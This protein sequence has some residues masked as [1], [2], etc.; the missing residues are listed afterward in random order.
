MVGYIADVV[1]FEEEVLRQLVLN[2]ERVL[3]DVGALQCGVDA[4]DCGLK[5]GIVSR[6][7]ADGGEIAVVVLRVGE[8]WRQVQ[9]RE[10]GVALRTEVE[11]SEAAADDRVGL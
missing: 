5:A 4:G 6:S 2:A 7:G 11:R 9:L 10:D 3:I 1:H 8:E